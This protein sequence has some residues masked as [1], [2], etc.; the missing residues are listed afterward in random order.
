M[1]RHYLYIR[2]WLGGLV[3]SCCVLSGYRATLYAVGTEMQVRD[4]VRVR[5]YSSNSLCALISNTNAYPL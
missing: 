1:C 2:N 3:Q 5:M 4:M